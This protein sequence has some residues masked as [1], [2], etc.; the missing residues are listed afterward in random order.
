M[1]FEVFTSG[2][3]EVDAVQ[4]MRGKTKNI[5]GIRKG[6]CSFGVRLASCFIRD[7]QKRREFREKHSK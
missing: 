1:V 2:D 4:V 5:F 7:K 6:R 3:D